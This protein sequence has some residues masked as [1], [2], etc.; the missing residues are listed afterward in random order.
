MT[1]HVLYSFRRCPYAMRAR[2]ALASSG[3]RYE[4]R[5][6]R[7]SDKPA[8]L[9]TASP[10]G[11]VPVLQTADGDLLEES[12]AIMRWALEA[13]DPETW[14]TRD[15]PALIAT[16]DGMFKYHLDRY[17]YP[18]RHGSES[19][20]DRDH[21]LRFLKDLDARIAIAGQLRG[22]T[23]GFADAAIM[24]F[25]RQ[26]AGVD[27]DWFEAQPLPYLQGWLASHLASELFDSVMYRVAPWSQGDRPI[28]VDGLTQ[29]DRPREPG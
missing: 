20:R 3:I 6:V 1:D 11:T 21:G 9:L 8:E 7:L 25:V 12:L 29:T 10:K 14:L 27:R 18:E 26:F 4:L 22:R 13:Q 24:P 16:N 2:L 15:D 23:R 28:I 5:E 17:K 19:E